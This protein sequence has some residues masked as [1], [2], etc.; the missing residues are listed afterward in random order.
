MAASKRC[1]IRGAL[2]LEMKDMEVE[3]VLATNCVT[4][5]AKRC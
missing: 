1:K 2:V 5:R 4:S 3:H